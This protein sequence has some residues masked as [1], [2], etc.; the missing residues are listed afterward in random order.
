MI[1][2]PPTGATSTRAPFGLVAMR[3]RCVGRGVGD[4]E[5]EGDAT[6][7]VVG[8]DV[9]PDTDVTAGVWAFPDDVDRVAIVVAVAPV[10]TPKPTTTSAVRTDLNRAGLPPDDMTTSPTAYCAGCQRTP[11]ARPC[12]G[13][14]Q[15]RLTAYHHG[16]YRPGMSTRDP[17]SVGDERTQLTQ[18]LDFQRATLLRKVEGL[19][20]DQLAV[21][22]AASDLTLA[23]L[24]KHMTLVEDHWFSVILHGVEPAAPWRDVDWEADPDWEFRTAVDDDP[25]DLVA[26][27]EQTC[28]RS[29][30]AVAAVES[31]DD[32]SAGQSR[33]TGERFNL[34]WILL[35][36][37]EET[38]RHLG[39]ADFLR[40]AID[41]TT[42]D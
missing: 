8:D 16:A 15:V 21:T 4:A 31:L 20:R 38:A 26:H 2:S 10:T 35:H 7:S 17:D 41:G 29:R 37:I 39:H 27:Y 6:P 33:R 36:I 25:A 22:T 28:A 13:G 18:F 1:G 30:D 42:G 23:G 5:T 3:M 24:L 11:A 34:R 9:A 19:D 12:C 40:E 14:R 32:L